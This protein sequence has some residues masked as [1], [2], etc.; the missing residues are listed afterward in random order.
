VGI[1]FIIVLELF[2]NNLTI[3]I[4]HIV[5]ANLFNKDYN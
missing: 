1:D 4:I 3:I 5:I 2:S